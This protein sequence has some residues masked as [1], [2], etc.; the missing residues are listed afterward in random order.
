MGDQPLRLEYIDPRTLTEHRD[1]WKVHEQPQLLSL[2]EL[3]N[4]VGWAGAVLVNETTG[5]MLDGHARREVAIHR[6][7]TAVPV[8]IGRWTPEQERL[9]LAKLDA[10]RAMAGTD[11][12][13]LSALLADLPGTTQELDDLL[14]GLAAGAEGAMPPEGSADAADP[15][16]GGES[17]ESLSGKSTI[18]A[19]TFPDEAAR[20]LFR[21]FLNRLA[22]DYPEERNAGGRL[23]AFLERH[24]KDMLE[25]ST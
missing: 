1:N 22:E 25:Q 16:G 9:I 14:A 18:H 10:T 19:I 5:V 20:E 13:K 15:G 2:D 17:E 12:A 11:R 8:L 21:T 24:H 4:Q 23:V 3:L 6:N 7:E